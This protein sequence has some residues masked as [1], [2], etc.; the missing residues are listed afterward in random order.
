MNQTFLS[1]EQIKELMSDDLPQDYVLDSVYEVENVLLMLKGIKEK[2]EYFKGLKKY[3]TKSIDD[4]IGDLTD[5]SS[6]L[7][8]VVLHTMKQLEPKKNTITFPSI[9]SVTRKKAKSAWNID[10]EESLVAFLDKQGYKDTVV[11]T[12]Q[13]IDA[14]KLNSVLDDFADARVS[15]PG[16][17]PKPTSESISIRFEE[18]EESTAVP[19]AE[20][21]SDALE[22][23]DVLD[24]LSV[25]DL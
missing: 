7:R 6:R 10:D 11:K 4:K 18:V 14:R 5:R 3:R 2:V 16:V 22:A 19:V 9:G 23:L 21:A 8:G 25:D 15:V 17:S 13:V 20:R 12:K 1:G 24:S